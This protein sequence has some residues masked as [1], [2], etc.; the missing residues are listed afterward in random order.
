MSEK[1][2]VFSVGDSLC[3]LP[4]AG[5]EK[6]I[7]AVQISP[8]PEAPDIIAGAINLAGQILPVINLRRRF[9]FADRDLKV[10]DRFIIVT[11]QKRT[12]ALMADAVEGLREVP[13]EQLVRLEDPLAFAPQLRGAAKIS[14]ELILIF[15]LGLFLSE[16]EERSLEKALRS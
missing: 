8:L 10:D 3:A 4:L 13:S 1:I 9:C 2:V 7:R 15:D 11:T 6:V 5:V 14:G 16:N 12:V